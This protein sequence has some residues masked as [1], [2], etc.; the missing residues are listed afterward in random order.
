[1]MCLRHQGSYPDL[2]ENGLALDF[3]CRVFWDNKTN[4]E[5]LTALL[6]INLKLP[7]AVM[8]VFA[9]LKARGN[10]QAEL[11]SMGL[12]VVDIKAVVNQYYGGLVQ[13]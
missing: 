13:V 10:Y 9:L 1:M 8:F 2:G 4:D 7:E 12:N 5:L 3:A 6:D 11:Q